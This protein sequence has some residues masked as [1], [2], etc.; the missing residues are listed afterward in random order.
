MGGNKETILDYRHLPIACEHFC[1]I[2]DM[3]NGGGRR[4]PGKKWASKINGIVA[5]TMGNGSAI[6]RQRPLKI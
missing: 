6:S 5:G 1:E 2:N 3:R 4:F